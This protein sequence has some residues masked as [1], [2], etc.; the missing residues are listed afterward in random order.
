MA[1]SRI[2][3][4]A[5]AFQMNSSAAHSISCRP[6]GVWRT[7]RNA[8]TLR[9]IEAAIL[10]VRGFAGLAAPEVSGGDGLAV[11]LV[12]QQFDEPRLM[13]DLFIQDAG[14]QVIRARIL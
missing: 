1:G 12:R 2:P 13:L 6:S 4:R 9:V 5:A 11:A 3:D 8:D 7:T 10:T 14:R